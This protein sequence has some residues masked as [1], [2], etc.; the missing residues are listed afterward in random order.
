MDARGR[1]SCFCILFISAKRVT[2]TRNERQIVLFLAKSLG[3]LITGISPIASGDPV[4]RETVVNLVNRSVD[5]L[6]AALRLM[7]EEWN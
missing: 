4:D 7:D 5:E 3:D 1:N 6:N 2:M